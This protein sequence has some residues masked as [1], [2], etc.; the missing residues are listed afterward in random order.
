MAFDGITVAAVVK[1]LRE[2]LLGGRIYKIAQHQDH[3]R[4]SVHCGFKGRVG[5]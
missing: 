4:Y 1:E 5:A 2:N 3:D